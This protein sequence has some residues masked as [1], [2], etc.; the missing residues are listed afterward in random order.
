MDV[1]GC[2]QL[3]NA[4]FEAMAHNCRL[5]RQLKASECVKLTADGVNAIV[6]KCLNLT[7]LELETC[8]YLTK[9]NFTD[10]H[11]NLVESTEQESGI[12]NYFIRDSLL[13]S[14][15]RLQVLDLSF[16][17]NIATVSVKQIAC[18]CPMLR[19]LSLRGCY[20][21]TDQ[22][23]EFLGKN[24]RLLN[25]LDISATTMNHSKL[26]DLSLLTL[27]HSPNLTMLSVTKNHS[28]TLN[29]LTQL[30]G[31]CHTLKRLNVTVG[32]EIGILDLL[33]SVRMQRGS[34]DVQ[35]ITLKN[36]HSE[37]KGEV[38]VILPTVKYAL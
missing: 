14:P 19:S 7:H 28:I 20:A 38:I 36:M 24:C 33:D 23:I 26:T 27:V 13:T 11:I 10:T 29:G 21:V 18:H 9:L 25:V 32:K 12:I 16:C 4:S 8:H 35:G 3:T 2:L 6:K 22:A 5:L 37:W 34:V 15:C 31:E 1:T 30:L 17:S